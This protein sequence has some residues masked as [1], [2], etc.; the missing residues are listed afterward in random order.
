[1]SAYVP[2]PYNERLDSLVDISTPSSTVALAMNSSGDVVVSLDFVVSQRDYS[3]ASY[4][5]LGGLVGADWS[6]RRY[7]RTTY[8]EQVATVAN[9]SGV[10]SLSAA[11]AIRTT[12]A[13][14]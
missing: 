12:L 9:N 1:M 6:V 10:A 5:Y 13:Y 2:Q 8:S 14:A 7:S 11:W 4:I 3:N